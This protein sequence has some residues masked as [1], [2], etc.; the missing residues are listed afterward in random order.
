MGASPSVHVMQDG[1]GSQ[2]E[3]QPPQLIDESVFSDSLDMVMAGIM[4]WHTMRQPGEE[5]RSPFTRWSG[6]GSP[7]DDLSWIALGYN[8]EIHEF[9]G[10]VY[11]YYMEDGGK[12]IA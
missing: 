9:Y 11:K 7:V 3:N 5:R 6:H 4:Y 10:G 12:T 2:F 1:L 8:F